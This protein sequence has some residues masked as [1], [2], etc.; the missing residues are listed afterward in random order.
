MAKDYYQVL[1]VKEDAT[2]NEIKKVYRELAKKYHPDA[3]NG[4][5]NAESR[6]KE[7]SEAYSVLSNPEKRK[8][9]DQMRRFGAFGPGNRQGFD[10][11]DFDLSDL[12]RLW[13]SRDTGQRGKGGF[14]FED[15]FGSG[16][17]GLGDIFEDLFDRGSKIRQERWGKKQKGESLHS[18]LTIPFEV[19]IKGGRQFINITK[20]EGCDVCKGTG[21]K[22]GTKPQTCPTCK[23]V[24]TIS[25]SQGFFAVNRPCPNCYGRGQ[26]IKEQCSAC[27]GSGEIRT[28]KRLAV[29]IPVGIENGTTLRLKKQGKPGIKG[30]EAGD[31]YVTIRVTP[32][33]FF[34]RTKNDVF[35]E[36]PLDILKAIKGTKI[37][38]NTPY[39]KKVEIKIPSH[40]IDGKSFR[41]KGM[42]IT[43]IKGSGDLFV[44]VRVTKGSKY[45][46]EEKKTIEAFESRNH[47]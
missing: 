47:T 27:S 40:T 38:I 45:S 19:A 44:T 25:M 21:A 13:K 7:I 41:L 35:C 43:S 18:E 34:S 14:S 1:S 16:G 22:P 10:F 36:V 11:S 20:E 15:L 8:Q 5:K 26:I 23:G 4:D 33:R 28:T 30:G 29:N 9:Y 46:P 6:F 3:N 31:I 39:D 24:G 17:F 32:H 37:R 12:G 2:T 42:G